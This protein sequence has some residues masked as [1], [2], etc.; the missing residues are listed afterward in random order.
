MICRRVAPVLVV[1]VQL[2]DVGVV[3]QLQQPDL[4]AQVVEQL[5]VDAAHLHAC[6][7]HAGVDR[8][9]LDRWQTRPVLVLSACA[10]A[11]I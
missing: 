10:N 9:E 5:R 11:H 1:L 8:Q 2:D 7:G 6:R 4:V 3:H